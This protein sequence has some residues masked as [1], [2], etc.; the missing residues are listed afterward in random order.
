MVEGRASHVKSR[1]QGGE[2]NDL[3][4]NREMWIKFGFGFGKGVWVEFGVRKDKNNTNY[5][6]VFTIIVCIY[7]VS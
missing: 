7:I 4:F 1:V 3:E 2:I 5:I 6:Y